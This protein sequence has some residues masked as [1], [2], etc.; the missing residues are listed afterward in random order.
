[1]FPADATE[2]VAVKEAVDETEL[3]LGP[4]DIVIP[5]AAVNT[6]RP[7]VLTPFEDWWTIMEINVKAPMMLTRMVLEGMLKRNSGSIIFIS[8]RA[9]VL[10]LGKESPFHVYSFH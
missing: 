8:S 7:Y 9:G 5:N 1:M 4:L 3:S 2:T 10:S 6:F